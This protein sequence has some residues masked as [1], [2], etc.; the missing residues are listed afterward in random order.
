MVRVCCAIGNS[1]GSFDVK[2]KQIV[3]E[4]CEDLGIPADGFNL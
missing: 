2:E 1:D 3:R 4:I